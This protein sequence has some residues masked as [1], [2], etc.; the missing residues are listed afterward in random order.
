MIGVRPARLA[1]LSSRRLEARQLDQ[2]STVTITTKGADFRDQGGHRDPAK[3]RERAQVRGFWNGLQEPLQLVGHSVE[4]VPDEVEARDQ[5]H[6]FTHTRVLPVRRGHRR[7]GLFPYL[8]D[9]E[10]PHPPPASMVLD[11][12]DEVPFRTSCDLG[13]RGGP[14]NSDRLLRWDPDH[15]EGVWNVPKETELPG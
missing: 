11:G 1:T 13:R 7:T 4:L 6:D 8:L 3:T 2:L 5:P 12:P 14:R 15:R 10:A 9:F